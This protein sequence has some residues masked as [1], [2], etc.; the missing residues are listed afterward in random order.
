MQKKT[1]HIL[2]EICLQ[3]SKWLGP[4]INNTMIGIVLNENVSLLFFVSDILCFLILY[5]IIFKSLQVQDSTTLYRVYSVCIF[6]SRLKFEKS[7]IYGSQTLES[8]SL[9]Q[10][11]M[12][13]G[14]SDHSLAKW[15]SQKIPFRSTFEKTLFKKNVFRIWFYIR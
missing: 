5:H 13:I 15:R 10:S 2:T 3:W 14:S 1:V 4:P 6:H 8:D 12:C 9:T 7:A 11:T